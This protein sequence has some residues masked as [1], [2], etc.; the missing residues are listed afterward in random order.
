MS[1]DPALND[2]VQKAQTHRRSAK[3]A[4]RDGELLTAKSEF[5]FALQYLDQLDQYLDKKVLPAPSDMESGDNEVASGHA[6]LCGVRGGTYRDMAP[7]GENWLSEAI[8]W[9]DT[10]AGYERDFR[11]KSTYNFVNQLVLRILKNPRLLDG[12]T[13]LL[14]LRDHKGTQHEAT[15]S[16][17]LTRAEAHVEWTI[18]RRTD[19]AWGYADLVIL[20][21]LRSSSNF[22]ARWINFVLQVK[23]D[24]DDYPFES[25]LSVVRDLVNL[26]IGPKTTL[27]ELG[28]DLRKQ[29]PKDR[30]GDP[31]TS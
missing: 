27:I 1:L 8:S 31:L 19:K 28:E 6:E 14:S 13:I 25:L 12:A 22:T 26:P 7:L 5:Q 3:K 2:F 9:Y 17:W 21:A 16:E 11:L 24:G 29:L 4:L 15:I 20:S 30:R 10:G 23:R 18:P